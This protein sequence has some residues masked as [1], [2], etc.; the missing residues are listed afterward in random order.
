METTAKLLIT[1]PCLIAA[2]ID[3]TFLQQGYVNERREFIQKL[4]P[5]LL[6]VANTGSNIA[7]VTGNSFKELSTRF[8][9]YLFKYLEDNSETEV[10]S[11]FH[12]FC[13][14]GGVYFHFNEDELKTIKKGELNKM[15]FDSKNA[16]Q[17]KSSFI[18]EEY[19]NKT[20]IE[21][22]DIVK[23]KNVLDTLWLEYLNDLKSNI[24]EYQKEYFIEKSPGKKSESFKYPIENALNDSEH[25]EVRYFNYKNDNPVTVQITVKPVLSWRHAINPKDKFNNDLRIKL[26]K[27]IH[28]RFDKIGLTKYTARTGGNTSIDITKSKLDKSYAIKYLIDHLG[29]E[30]NERK[31]ERFG[32]NVIYMGDEVISGGGN[33]FPITKID[34]VLV[35]AVNKIPKYVPF[36]SRVIIPNELTGPDASALVLSEY[37]HIVQ[38]ELTKWTDRITKEKFPKKNAVQLFKEKWFSEKI[39]EK[40]SNTFFEKKLST[41]ELQVLYTFITLINRSDESAKKWTNILVNELDE[42]MEALDKSEYERLSGIGSS[43]EKEFENSDE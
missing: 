11:K 42:I 25:V 38:K 5:E 15:I 21:Q 43:Y 1:N 7:V 12:F 27:S 23:I 40:I 20:K 24:L 9:K 8:L 41:E 13:N 31:S 22:N 34:G 10:L 14:S 6:K 33:D 32:S 29:I 17:I 18:N 26:I 16:N 36:K 3:K 28:E 2:D 35:L 39:K 37:N 4:A 19:L 30:G